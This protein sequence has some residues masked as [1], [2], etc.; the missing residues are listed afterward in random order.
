MAA[1]TRAGSSVRIPASKFR[2]VA[3]FMPIPAPVR[4]AEPM[5]ATLQSKMIILK[6]T[7]GHSALSSPAKRTGY[8]SKSSRK[9]G[10]GSLAWI[11]RTSLPFDIKSARIPRKGRSPTYRSL[12]SAVPIQRER[13]TFGT[14]AMTALS[15]E[16]FGNSRVGNISRTS[17]S[18]LVCR[19]GYSSS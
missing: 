18:T 5:Y 1:S 9:F 17:S 12:M 14:R 11:R 15:Y 4:L 7:R 2:V 6:W 13:L 3:P 8:R 10:P 16:L 19:K